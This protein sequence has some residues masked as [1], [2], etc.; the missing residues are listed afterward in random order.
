MIYLVYDFD[1]NNFVTSGWICLEFVLEFCAYLCFETSS[2][3]RMQKIGL[4]DRVKEK[5]LHRVKEER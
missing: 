1:M 4:T 2:Q 5:V 3:R